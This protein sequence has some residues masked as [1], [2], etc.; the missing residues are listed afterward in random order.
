MPLYLSAVAR[1]YFQNG[2]SMRTELAVR[3]DRGEPQSWARRAAALLT[4]IFIASA[5]L[6]TTATTS[7]AATKYGTV[8]VTTQRMKG[9]H[10]T[11][12]QQ[13]GTYA[14]GKKL[15]LTCYI[16]GQVVIGWGGKSNLWYKISDGYYAADVDLYTGSNNP[17]TVACPAPKKAPLSQRVDAFIK[18]WDG[19]RADYDK[20]FGA[21]CVDLFTYYG[22]E[23]VGAKPEGGDA[24]TRYRKTAGYTRVSAGSAAKKGDVAVWGNGR[25]GH[26]A[27]VYKDTAANSKTLPIFSQNHQAPYDGGRNS[28]AAKVPS[29]SKTGLLGYLRPNS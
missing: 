25:Y 26:I 21:Q 23:V 12:Y 11:N 8:M 24:K 9:P 10:L 6:I 22:L 16:R 5:T 4:A 17:I 20:A 18:K 28:K 2:G 14:K 7:E 13:V 29:Y 3:T 19:K 27:I 1:R 15:T